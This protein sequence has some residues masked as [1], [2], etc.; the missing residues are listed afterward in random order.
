ML[1]M[2]IDSFPN[3]SGSSQIE[4]KAAFNEP[5]SLFIYLLSSNHGEHINT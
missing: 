3:G 5:N 1:Y 4:V 2:A